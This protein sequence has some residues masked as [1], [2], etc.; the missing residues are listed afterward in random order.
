MT[1]TGWYN[2]ERR[3][4]NNKVDERK[5]IITNFSTPKKQHTRRR[6]AKVLSAI[7]IFT[8]NMIHSARK[9]PSEY[10]ETRQITNTTMFVEHFRIY[11]R[12]IK[13]IFP[14]FGTAITE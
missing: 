4:E 7:D 11:E 9:A 6:K 14:L 5:T 13:S 12:R 10:N 3:S 1:V 8:K 2:M